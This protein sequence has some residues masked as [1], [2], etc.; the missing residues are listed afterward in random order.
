MDSH[1]LN[2]IF[3]LLACFMESLCSRTVNL[4]GGEQY[5]S[6][7]ST[8]NVKKAIRNKPHT[9]AVHQVLQLIIYFP[10]SLKISIFL[11]TVVLL[12]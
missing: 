5:H 4:R 10:S 3:A 12:L 1:Q 6:T 2:A 11:P 9:L 8:T 7:Y